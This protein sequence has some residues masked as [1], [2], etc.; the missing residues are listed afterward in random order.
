MQAI[1]IT[2]Y[3]CCAYLAV[4]KLNSWDT[5]REVNYYSLIIKINCKESVAEDILSKA[6]IH[7]IIQF[8]TRALIHIDKT[9]Q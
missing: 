4:T 5:I 7:Q 6:F 8:H 2:L 9:L 1:I 3:S